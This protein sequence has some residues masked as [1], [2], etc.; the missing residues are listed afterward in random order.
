MEFEYNLM[1]KSLKLEH[2][3]IMMQHEVAR[4]KIEKKKFANV[5]TKNDYQ[6]LEF[7]DENFMIIT[8][9]EA[10]ELV[11]EGK[12]LNHC[13]ASYFNRVIQG[14]SKILFMR[15]KKKLEVPLVT[16][17]VCG[18]TVM[19][20]RGRSNRDVNKE[21]DKFIKKWAKERKLIV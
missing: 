21:E 1:P 15:D 8:P 16:I 9:K 10:D 2:D 19:Q 11:K 3:V 4:T 7:Q 20:A 6:A 18:R 14:D 12:Q 5:I 17:E 13:V